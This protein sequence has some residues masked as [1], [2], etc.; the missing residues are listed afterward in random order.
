MRISLK[1]FRFRKNLWFLLLFLLIYQ[2]FAFN[3]ILEKGKI[4]IVFVNLAWFWTALCSFWFLSTLVGLVLRTPLN[5]ITWKCVRLFGLIWWR[6]DVFYLKLILGFF[7][8]FLKEH[9]F[10]YFLEVEFIFDGESFESVFVCVG[11]FCFL[12]NF[13]ILENVWIGD[14]EVVQIKS[15]ML[16]LHVRWKI[17]FLRNYYSNSITVR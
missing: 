9:D 17:L 12:I 3:L 13:D 2:S 4:W 5:L 14:R 11:I 8:T 6:W 1:I 16:V 15:E 7:N 10:R